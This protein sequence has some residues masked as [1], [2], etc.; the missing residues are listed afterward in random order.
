MKKKLFLLSAVLFMTAAMWGC[1]S[2]KADK[3]ETTTQESAAETGAQPETGSVEI[4]PDTPLWTPKETEPE[5]EP[6]PEPLLQGR[7]VVD[8]PEDFYE[9]LSPS[10]I[11]V[12]KKYPEDGSNIY[13][14]ASPLYGTLP[15]ESEYTRKINE[16]LS[17]QAG[18]VVSVKMEEY[19][20]TTVDGFEASRAV[21][22]Y[23]YDGMKFRRTEY[24]VNT[25]IT[26]TIAYTQVG[27]ADWEDEF[28]ASALSMRVE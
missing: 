26:T 14:V 21:Y 22:S 28:E 4:D 13:I 1:G 20:K 6:E 15:E 5:P 9:Y 10:G 18:V 3:E 25:N 24:T 16:S 8:I 11:Y 27:S 19:E 12:T 7:V 17:A 23:S 2:K